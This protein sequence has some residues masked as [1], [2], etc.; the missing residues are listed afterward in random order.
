MK[1]LKI[2]LP[3]KQKSKRQNSVARCWLLTRLW[4]EYL[5]FHKVLGFAMFVKDMVKD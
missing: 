2:I 4:R 3:S 5:I 1:S